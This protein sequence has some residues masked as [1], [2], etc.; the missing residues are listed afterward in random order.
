MV[1]L[2]GWISYQPTVLDYV[3]LCTP[4]VL[5]NKV[6]CKERMPE[7]VSTT[8]TN[9]PETIKMRLKPVFAQGTKITCDLWSSF[10]AS[11]F[12]LTTPGEGATGHHRWEISAGDKCRHRRFHSLT[13]WMDITRFKGRIS[14]VFKIYIY[15]HTQ[16]LYS[17]HTH[18]F[19]D[20]ISHCTVSPLMVI[21]MI[22]A[23]IRCM[24]SS[25]KASNLRSHLPYDFSIPFAKGTARMSLHHLYL[26]YSG[27][28]V[29][30]S[31]DGKRPGKA[32]QARFSQW[33]LNQSHMCKGQNFLY[34]GWS[35]H[36]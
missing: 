28:I 24:K 3:K 14:V 9:L 7:K 30:C 1:K 25:C 26:P 34:W 33:L 31:R 6:F 35:S 22:C 21:N 19:K 36:P 23:S 10:Q 18:G 13:D 16:S 32:T 15:T 17:P 27:T 20:S 5:N 29:V 12:F 11:L 8:N 4:K 2:R